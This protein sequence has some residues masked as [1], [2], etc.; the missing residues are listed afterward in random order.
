MKPVKLKSFIIIKMNTCEDKEYDKII[1]EDELTDLFQLLSEIGKSSYWTDDKTEALYN[2]KLALV[3]SFIKNFDYYKKKNVVNSY[4]LK[5][6]LF[7][8]NKIIFENTDRK[9][10]ERLTKH[11][12]VDENSDVNEE[13]LYY[14]SIFIIIFNVEIYRYF[15]ISKFNF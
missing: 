13:K 9:E 14:E 6:G 10:Y 4:C 3:D 1:M 2:Y 8:F 5:K 12:N 11:F 15:R 7:E